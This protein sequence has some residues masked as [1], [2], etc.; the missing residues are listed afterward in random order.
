M[1]IVFDP[2]DGLLF[3]HW[4]IFFAIF[5]SDSLTS[6]VD[7]YLDRFLRGGSGGG[8]LALHRTNTGADL[9][10][11]LVCFHYVLHHQPA[12]PLIVKHISGTGFAF[13]ATNKMFF[14][15]SGW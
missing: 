11:G 14:W 6:G 13:S 10:Q 12:N 7:Y 15:A 5:L 1:A 2:R 8:S 3:K 9:N 4:S